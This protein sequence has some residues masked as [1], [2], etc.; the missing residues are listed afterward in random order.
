MAK[1]EEMTHYCEENPNIYC[2]PGQIIECDDCSR[3]K[4][5]S[6]FKLVIVKIL[7]FLLICTFI[8]DIF[9]GLF[10]LIIL[11]FGVVLCKIGDKIQIWAD[12]GDSR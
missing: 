3:N 4:N 11:L 10:F 8:Y 6:I 9:S 12:K 2:Y 5:D 7:L 1:E